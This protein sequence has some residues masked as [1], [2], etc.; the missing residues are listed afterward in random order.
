MDKAAKSKFEKQTLRYIESKKI[1]D[2]LENL[3]RKLA[4]HQPEKPLDFLIDTLTH[5]K[6]TFF[7]SVIGV[8]TDVHKTCENI[9]LQLNLHH[10]CLGSLV[11]REIK[12]NLKFAKELKELKAK[13]MKSIISIP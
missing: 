9:S 7:I 5:K 10:I 3:M 8:E 13:R 12:N 4:L 2:V 11:D 1:Y 6:P